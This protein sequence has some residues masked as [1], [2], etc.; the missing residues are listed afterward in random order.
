MSFIGMFMGA[1]LVVKLVIV[2]LIAASIVTSTVF[3]AIQA[4]SVG[5]AVDEPEIDRLVGIYH[6]LLRRWARV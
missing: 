2:G 4:L 6:N 3:L 1:D 5:R